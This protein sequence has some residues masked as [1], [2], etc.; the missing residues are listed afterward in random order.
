MANVSLVC[1]TSTLWLS[2]FLECGV[3]NNLYNLERK[4]ILM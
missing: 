4:I 2:V 3:T 1:L